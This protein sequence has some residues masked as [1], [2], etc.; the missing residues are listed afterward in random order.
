MTNEEKIA[1]LRQIDIMDVDSGLKNISNLVPAYLRILGLFAKKQLEDLVFSKDDM[2]Q[3]ST[4]VH[5]Y[6]SLLANIG[7]VSLSVEANGLEQAAKSGDADFIEANFDGFK[8]KVEGLAAQL[9]EIL[10]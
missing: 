8:S 2:G 4:T 10:G 1:L 7:A 6:R 9:R 3:F 5:G